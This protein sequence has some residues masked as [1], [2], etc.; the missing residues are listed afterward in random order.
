MGSV[1]AAYEVW[2]TLLTGA[3]GAPTRIAGVMPGRQFALVLTHPLKDVAVISHTLHVEGVLFAKEF[4]AGIGWLDTWF[5]SWFYQGVGGL[6]LLAVLRTI[7]LRRRYLVRTAWSL[8][9]MVLATIALMFTFYLVD[10]PYSGVVITG[11]QGRYLLPLLPSLLVVLG[12][13]SGSTPMRERGIA[14]V[15]EEYTAI[16][17]VGLQLMI[18][19]AFVMTLLK[20]YWM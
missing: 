9:V 4:L 17:L 20:R 18:Y 2:A 15:V 7:S 8:L 6:L 19:A 5:P 14:K 13:Q 11:F 3:R 1:G 16:G 12:W 10:T